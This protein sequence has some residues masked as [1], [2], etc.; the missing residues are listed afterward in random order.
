MERR[1]MTCIVCPNGCELEVSVD[2]G[3][4]MDVFGN[5]CM[6]GYI[7]AQN[8]VENPVRTFTSTVEVTDAD[9]ERV[10]VKTERDIPK[11][12]IMECAAAL[13]GVK[14][15]APV[16]IGDVIV[17]NIAGTGVNIVST[18]KVHKKQSF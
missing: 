9:R 5:K 7:Y 3:E 12:K 8:E 13:K 10:S 14:V 17:N 6:R 2:D 18:V 11:A 1:K 4:V 15:K 16:E